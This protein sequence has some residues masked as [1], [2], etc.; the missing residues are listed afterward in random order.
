MRIAGATLTAAHASPRPVRPLGVPTAIQRTHHSDPAWALP[1]GGHSRLTYRGE[2]RERDTHDHR[3]DMGMDA[4]RLG[5]PLT[6]DT[7]QPQQERTCMQPALGD[8]TPQTAC[9]RHDTHAGAPHMQACETHRAHAHAHAQPHM[10][11][12]RRARARPKK[13]QQHVE[14]REIPATQKTSV[15]AARGVGC[16]CRARNTTSGTRTQVP[17]VVL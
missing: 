12:G 5:T 10:Q 1:H 4:R 17:L 6:R 7:P 13:E 2:R 8:Q 15:P 11:R 3:T 16:I 9:S 14:K